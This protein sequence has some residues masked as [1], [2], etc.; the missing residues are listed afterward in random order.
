L[1][2]LN[3]FQANFYLFRLRETSYLMPDYGLLYNVY[4]A[5]CTC[6]NWVCVALLAVLQNTCFKH[7]LTGR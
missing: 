2:V 3:Q 7:R 1:A 5:E 4:L 6:C